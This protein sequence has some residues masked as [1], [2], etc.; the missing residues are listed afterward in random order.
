M[1]CLVQI[2]NFHNCVHVSHTG[3]GGSADPEITILH[4]ADPDTSAAGSTDQP[5][6]SPGNQ[7]LSPRRL[8]TL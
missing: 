1:Y 8:W 7:F 6:T 4:Q 3:D 2:F 5:S